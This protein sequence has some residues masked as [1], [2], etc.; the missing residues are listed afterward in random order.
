MKFLLLICIL[1]VIP[2]HTVSTAKIPPNAITQWNNVALRG[3]RDAKVAAPMAARAFSITDTCM[4]DAWAAYDSQA[5]GT[6]LSGALSRPASERTGANKEKAISYAAYRALSDLFP[7]E[8]ESTYKPLMRKLGYDPN[9]HSTDIETPTGIGNVTC[10]AVLEYRHH[11]KSNQLGEMDSTAA[12]N[13]GKNGIKMSAIGAYADWTGYRPVNAPGMVP[14]R[15]PLSKPLN[16]NHWQ[17]LTY[18]DSNGSLV[19]QMFAGAQWCF[20]TPF[21]MSKGDEFRSTTEPGPFQY[22]SPEYEQQAQELID[23]SVNLTDRQKMI[24]EYW[25]GEANGAETI[26]HWLNFA[27]FVSAR[28]HHTLDDDV[29][30]YF[31]LT[32]AMLDASIA[33]WDAKREYDSVR[34]ITAI[35]FLFNGKQ[36]RAWGGPGKGS[37]EMDGSKW[38]PY[39]PSTSPTPPSPEYPSGQSAFS[40][41]AAR[42]LALWTGSDRFGDSIELPK[43]SS[44]IEPGITPRE[45]VVLKWETFTQAA[46]EA[47]ISGLYAG[48]HFRRA[49]LAGPKLGRLVADKVWAK[50]QSYFSRVYQP[51]QNASAP[52]H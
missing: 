16:P 44:K 15:F 25:S 49:D 19:L 46:D 17:P 38:V 42:I 29:K 35:S 28:D 4:Y 21:A 33:V 10:A 31:A 37:V 26:E 51:P 30:M 8:V 50:A 47:G 3:V 39:Q 18:T 43:G 52:A 22:G 12:E 20:I 34:P 24:A 9:D 41:A 32:N 14:T 40:S 45:S 48:I 36:I 2:A 7:E 27:E 5:I 11:D 23:F 6:Q 13:A 1:L